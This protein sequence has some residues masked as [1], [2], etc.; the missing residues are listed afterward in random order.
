MR[1]NFT[2]YAW[3]SGVDVLKND[4]IY[5]RVYLA[6]KL[7][8]LYHVTF[9]LSGKSGSVFR[10]ETFTVLNNGKYCLDIL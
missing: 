10:K 5:S 8:G 9:A 3:I 1:Y 2:T 7:N 6:P 4:G